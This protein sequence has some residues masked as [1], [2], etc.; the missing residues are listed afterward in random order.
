MD[1]DLSTLSERENSIPAC[2]MIFQ[3]FSYLHVSER[4]AKERAFIV[5]TCTK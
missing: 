3:V 4:A 5:P 2:G 1:L